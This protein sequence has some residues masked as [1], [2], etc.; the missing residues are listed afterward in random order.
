[1]HILNPAGFPA[2]GVALFGD[3]L[4]HL[5]WRRKRGVARRRDA[6]LAHR[7]APDF[8]DFL[9]HF[10]SRQHAAMA[11]LRT[12]AD[13][14]LHHLDLVVARDARELTGVELA[15]ARA[16]AEIAGADLPDDVAAHLAVIGADAA[17]AGVMGKA[18]LLRAGIERTHGVRA[19]CTKAHRRDV[20]DGCRVRP[21][22]VRTTDGDAEFLG[23]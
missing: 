3:E 4:H 5:A 22:A 17:L 11:G 19:Q 1:M 18:A 9:R 14:Q 2:R 7:H 21:G 12:L 6:V 23:R 8:G 13:L 16:A 20:E 15:V 10:R